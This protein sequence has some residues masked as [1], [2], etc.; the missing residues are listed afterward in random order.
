METVKVDLSAVTVN[1]IQQYSVQPLLETPE[2]VLNRILDLVE[3][4]HP[5]GIK[6]FAVQ[7]ERPAPMEY[8]TSR[9]VKLPI[10]LKLWAS[11]RS[12]NP[13]AEVTAE[14]FK[15]EGKFYDDPSAAA[16]AAKLDAGVSATASSTNGW[17]FWMVKALDSPTGKITSIDVFR[18]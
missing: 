12:T 11:Y 7:T 6:T 8:T 2:I 10:G 5:P 16:K 17:V 14:G 1:R 15:Y 9:G 13:R 4:K 3:G 18:K